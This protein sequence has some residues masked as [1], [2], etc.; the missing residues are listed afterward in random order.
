[1]RP[2]NGRRALFLG[3]V[4]AVGNLV[5]AVPVTAGIEPSPWRPVSM[6]TA[7]LVMSNGMPFVPLSELAKALGGTGRYD[8]VRLK[9][10]IRPGPNGV[11]LVNPGS[12]ATLGAGQ[13]SRGRLAAQNALRLSIGG[14]DVMID[15]E[16]HLLLRPA[17]PAISVR[18]LARLLGGQAKF[19]PGTG[20]W[21]LPP[22]GPGSPLRFR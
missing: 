15:D 9:Y 22:G 1:M 3:V 16:E 10:E 5:A 14:Q 4:V 12:L 17:D 11:L 21:V 8:P 20:A 7:N 18:F 2:C 6:V 13:I 19:D